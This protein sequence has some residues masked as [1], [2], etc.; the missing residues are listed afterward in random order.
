[1]F[2]KQVQLRLSLIKVTAIQQ[3]VSVGWMDGSA[4]QRTSITLFVD[5]FQRA[6]SIFFSH[7]KAT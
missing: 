4:K 5:H 7:L 2:W 1:M 6:L 3:N